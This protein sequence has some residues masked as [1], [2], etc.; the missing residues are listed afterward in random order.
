MDIRGNFERR[1]M[2][3]K[4]YENLYSEIDKAKPK[5]ILEIGTHVGK[6]AVKMI[7]KA[8]EHR[9]G[10]FY[11]GFDLFE[12]MTDE[13]KKYEFHGKS[14]CSYSQAM[15][16]LN[17][18][19]CPCKLKMGNTVKTLPKF[20]PDRPIDFIFIDGGHSIGTIQSDWD[21]IKRFIHD[22]TVVIF[23]DYY[24]NRDDV[25]CKKIIENIED[26]MVELLDPLDV[27]EVN[28]SDFK[29]LHIRL[30]KVGVGWSL[31]HGT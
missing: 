28:G 24:E 27:L 8:R 9:E 2:G 30:A 17:E 23:D 5:T 3:I 14:A 11:Y 10:V 31:R 13:Y 21:N 1:T 6:T 4:R 25:G 19:E 16:R 29:D 12:Y 20:K 18:I 7:K 15:K 22:K 26:F